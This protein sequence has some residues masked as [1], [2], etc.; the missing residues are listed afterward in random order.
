MWRKETLQAV[1]IK[2]LI[3]RTFMQVKFILKACLKI[4][5]TEKLI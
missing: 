2:L 5:N 1:V 4:E 3:S